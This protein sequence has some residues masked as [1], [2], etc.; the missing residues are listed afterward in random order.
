MKEF[1]ELLA[2]SDRLLGTDGCPWDREQTLKTLQP[3]LLEEIHELIEA[4]DC[5]D[6]I[7]M[8]E[9]VGDVFYT[10]IFTVKLAE[11]SEF[12]C[13]QD[14][15][16]EVAEK[17]IRR[18]PHVFASQK[19]TSTDEVVDNWEAIKSQERM[20]KNRKM[21]LDGIP[22]TLPTLPGVQKM[23]NKLKKAK[24]PL[25]PT[26]EKERVDEEEIGE[27]LWCLIAQAEASYIDAESA[28]RRYAQ[29][30]KKNTG[31]N[32]QQRVNP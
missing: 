22:P 32:S 18:H 16:V 14:A 24:S 23:L 5:E 6:P 17:L 4:I 2:I 19:V 10:L 8:C 26:V 28:L 1:N 13:L 9:E 29:K 27:K 30:I 31:D 11:K 12:F 25:F 21:V 20:S 15:L 7:K 3:Y